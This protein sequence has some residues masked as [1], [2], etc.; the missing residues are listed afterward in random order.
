MVLSAPRAQPDRKVWL[1]RRAVPGLRAPMVQRDRPV[2]PVRPGLKAHQ[3]PRARSVLQASQARQ[4]AMA[5]RARR[6]RR[7]LPARLE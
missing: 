5:P 1:L 3:D 6:E 4:A 7:G 2:Q